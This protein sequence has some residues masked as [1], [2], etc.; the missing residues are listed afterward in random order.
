M[1]LPAEVARTL[2]IETAYGAGLPR[3]AGVM[4]RHGAARRR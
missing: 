3:A 2:S 1:G 4:R